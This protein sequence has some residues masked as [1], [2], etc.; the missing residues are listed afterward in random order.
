VI[1]VAGKPTTPK[2]INAAPAV[3]IENFLTMAEILKKMQRTKNVN[4]D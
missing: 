4:S 3:T 2:A 1:A